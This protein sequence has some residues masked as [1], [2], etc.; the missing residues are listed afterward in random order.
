LEDKIGKKAIKNYKEMQ[1]G[2]VVRTYADVSDLERDT[3][4]KPSTPL[5]EGL[6]NFVAW[7]KDYYNI[8]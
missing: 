6:E 5:E 2:D 4:Y 3:G 1:P 8:Q 7:Y